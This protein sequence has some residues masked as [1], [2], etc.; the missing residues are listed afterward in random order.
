M[1]FAQLRRYGVV[2]VVAVDTPEQGLRLCEALAEGGL[3]VAEITFRTAAAEAT[4]RA[5]VTRFPDMILGA[6]TVLTADQL[7]RAMD[8]GARFAVAPGCTPTVVE[9]AV[10]ASFPFAP[11]VC[12]PS[13]VERAFGLGVR[14][15]KFFPA[16]AA[17]GVPLLKALIGPYGHLGLEFCPTGGIGPANLASY[18]ALPQVAFVGGTWIAPRERVSAGDWQAIV[19]LAGD[20]VAAARRP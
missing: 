20:A 19:A 14:M 12:T 15:L 3:P 1:V 13:D 10:A 9:R 6:G 17:G 11:G 16:E 2:P 5:A 18:L 4:I 7:A 8:A